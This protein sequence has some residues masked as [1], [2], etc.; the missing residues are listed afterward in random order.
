MKEPEL[1]RFNFTNQVA[2]RSVQYSASER[3]S[4]IEAGVKM[5]LPRCDTTGR[6]PDGLCLL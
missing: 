1:G 6:V 4:D 2:Q 5:R 3:A